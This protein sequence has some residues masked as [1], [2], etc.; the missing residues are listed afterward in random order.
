LSLA[1]EYLESVPVFGLVERFDLFIQALNQHLGSFMTDAPLLQSFEA[2]VLQGNGLSVEDIT[3]IIRCDI[4]QGLFDELLDRNQGDLELYARAVAR[5]ERITTGLAATPDPNGAGPNVSH[6]IQ[7]GPTRAPT[8]KEGNLGSP[9]APQRPPVNGSAR[10]SPVIAAPPAEAESDTDR[11]AALTADHERLQRRARWQRDLLERVRAEHNQDRQQ[12]DVLRAKYT[13]ALRRAMQA[14]ATEPD[15]P[16]GVLPPRKLSSAI[17]L[18]QGAVT[19]ADRAVNYAERRIKEYPVSPEHQHLRAKIAASGFFDVDFYT[20]RH[21]DVVELGWDPIDHYLIHGGYEGRAASEIFDTSWYLQRYPDVVEAGWHPLIHYLDHGEREGRQIRAVSADLYGS[22]PGH[23]S[24]GLPQPADF[25]AI[26]ADLSFPHY[27]DDDVEITVVVPIYNAVDHTLHCLRSLTE[28]TTSRRFEVLVMDDCSDDPDVKHLA[29]IDGLRYHRNDTNLGFLGNCNRS[30]DLAR[31]QYLVLLNNDTT[32]D[33]EWLDALR[34][35]FDHQTQVGVVGSK[36][37][38]PDGRLQ[39]AGGIIW[40]DAGGWNWGRLQDPAHP[41]FNYVR[42]VDYVSGASFMVPL[43]LFN[44]LGRFDERF[45]P[46]YYEDTDF[47]FTARQAGWRVLYQP[48]SVVVHYEGVSSGT[49]LSA[50][51]KKYQVTNREV[52]ADKWAA[53]LADHGRNGHA[54]LEACDR[55]PSGHVLI[56]DSCVPTPDRDS[57]SLDMINLIRILN[58]LGQRVHFLPLHGPNPE[59]PYTER[60]QQL[61]V[62]TL[63]APHIES[64]DSY[65]AET[66]S[67]FDN[68]ILSRVEP[69][70]AAIDTVL[71]RCPDANVVFY[72]VDLHH[73]RDRREAELTGDRHAA[74]RAAHQE[75]LELSLMDRVDTTIVLSEAERQMLGAAGKTNVA[76]LPLIREASPDPT[77]TFEDREGVVFVGGFRHPPNVDGVEWLLQEVWPRLRTLAEQRGVRV[78]TLT[79]AG[80]NMPDHLWRHEGP[81][82]AIH[83]FVE[84]LRPLF[85][86]ARL[87]VAPLRYGAGLKGKVATSLDFGVPVVGTSM[88]FEGMPTAGLEP[89][90]HQ[91]DDPEQLA[92]RVIELHDDRQRWIEA[93]V[94]GRNYVKRHYSLEALTPIV[95]QLVGRP[96][97]EIHLTDP[98]QNRRDEGPA[99]GR[100]VVSLP[101]VAPGRVQS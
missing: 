93:S 11:L 87:S 70:S 97:A 69:A 101:A 59:S 5:F 15:V 81:G 7:T 79:I 63:H 73:L 88:A 66:A 52:F 100:P 50:G 17:R 54:P 89:I 92:R 75:R 24:F 68:V 34:D 22:E 28:L 62:V 64:L 67:L 74:E 8:P 83:G 38:Y 43:D 20:A 41:R 49:D 95:A 91:A 72:T 60:L 6:S 33:P 16:D 65:L 25:G 18:A 45:R 99:A 10:S 96:L 53:V 30:A 32:V 86:R 36:L 14:E 44:Q 80:S 39:E 56:V 21:P 57:G 82:I 76:V 84:N 23:G 2:N 35:T 71:E 13:A 4:G 85:E 46:A 19:F 61:G 55:R 90:L 31:G 48:A 27:G 37:V 78:P 40:E 77:T 9:A 51:V 12:L 42:D 47:C 58:R 26:A 94:A 1:T 29:A 3:E 98:A